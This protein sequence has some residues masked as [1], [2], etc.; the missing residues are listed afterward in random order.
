MPPGA[1]GLESDSQ[2]QTN[3]PLAEHTFL[4]ETICQLAKKRI[5]IDVGSCNRQH[6]SRGLVDPDI[7]IAQLR[8]RA[9][10]AAEVGIRCEQRVIENVIEIRS[11]SRHHALS[12]RE[13]LVNTQ[14][15]APC[16]R[17]RQH[18]SLG[19]SR[20]AEEIGSDRGETE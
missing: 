19:N 8:E 16:P 7:K 15:H 4:L 20:V 1:S 17:P 13:G 9:S 12:D 2:S 10:T 5:D 3:G 11:E 6:R 14:I 18:I